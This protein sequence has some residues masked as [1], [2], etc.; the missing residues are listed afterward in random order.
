MAR[1]RR[2]SAATAAHSTLAAEAQ[3]ERETGSLPGGGRDGRAVF[4]RT[5]RVNALVE[6][7]EAEHEAWIAVYNRRLRP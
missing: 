3:F 6:N 7:L 1:R 4:L 5:S 2:S